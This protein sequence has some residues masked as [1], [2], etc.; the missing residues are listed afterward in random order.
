[1]IAAAGGV[2]WRSTDWGREIAVVHRPRYDDW[3]L[4]KGKLE[5]GESHLLAAVREV[6][7]ETGFDVTPGSSLGRTAYDAGGSRKQVRWW[8]MRYDG[9]E[10]VPNAEVDELR[11]VPLEQA[12]ALVR[13]KEPLRHAA[14]LA[15]DAS[16]VLL[17]R[18]ASAGDADRWAGND[19]ERPLDARGVQQAAAL[20]RLLAVYRPV[21]LLSAPPLRCR[22]TI[23]PLATALGAQVRL[24]DEVGEHRAPADP[25]RVV[26]GLSVPGETVVVCSQ[27]GVIPRV[28]HALAPDRA[29]V[30][31]A[32][33][34]VW[35]LTLLDG[36]A[37]VADDE[38]LP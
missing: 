7:E 36:R 13:E 25:D 12:H 1:M 10:F 34:S 3:S 35:A 33:G 26:L 18:H 37:V 30:R 17:V 28:V 5:P 22:Q 2:V 4:P 20:A 23:A 8:S 27:G 29:P 14:R 9:G 24:V 15:P 19:D 6:R 38:V 16:L 11:W 32:K 31:A 21:Q